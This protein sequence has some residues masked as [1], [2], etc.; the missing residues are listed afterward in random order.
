MTMTTTSNAH[1][2]T[3][4][5][6]FTQRST[7][8]DTQALTRLAFAGRALAAM[9]YVPAKLSAHVLVRRALEVYVSHLDKLLSIDDP[10]RRELAHL[11]ELNRLHAA[12]RYQ[13]AFVTED[14]VMSAESGTTYEAIVKAKLHAA[15]SPLEAV[16][17]RL[18][19]LS[20]VKGGR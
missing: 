3:T 20:V 17:G 9:G 8:Y 11:L 5:G 7:Q 18:S 6:G 2:N 10:E 15:K 14:D 12:E 19:N 4:R 1:S 16:K 13:A